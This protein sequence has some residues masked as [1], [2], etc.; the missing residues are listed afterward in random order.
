MHF[1]RNIGLLDSSSKTR[2]VVGHYYVVFVD[3]VY[4]LEFS[5]LLNFAIKEKIF[6]DMESFEKPVGFPL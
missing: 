1:L 2:K 3:G 6:I 5:C 4:V